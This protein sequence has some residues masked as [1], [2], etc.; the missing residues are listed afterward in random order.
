MLNKLH[1]DRLQVKLLLMV[2]VTSL[3]VF[4]LL[5]LLG[6]NDRAHAIARANTELGSIAHFASLGVEKR[7]APDKV[8]GAVFTSRELTS[9]E[10]SLSDLKRASGIRLILAD[11]NGIVLG[12]SPANPAAIG[13]LFPDQRVLD[14]IRA[15]TVEAFNATDDDSA[16]ILSKIAIV[17]PGIAVAMHTIASIDRA[18]VVSSV[19]NSAY[20][21]LALG[22][23]ALVIALALAWL[24]SRR[25][26][27]QRATTISAVAKQISMGKFRARTGFKS[28]P[29]ELEQIGFVIDRMADSL[30][31]RDVDLRVSSHRLS[32]AQ[33]I[34]MLGQW[35]LDV[36][37]NRAWWSAD[38]MEMFSIKA[39]DDSFEAFL[40]WVHPDDRAHLVAA[41]ARMLATGATMWNIGLSAPMAD[42]VG[43]ML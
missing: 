32:E 35:E 31:Q 25:G 19:T 26:A 14:A 38:A 8:S 39:A 27:T 4:A 20:L 41:N 6:L 43:F 15:G 40:E 9:L 3:P 5:F 18:V 11:R 29:D 37:S 10:K 17:K 33:R 24:L 42:R 2:C 36:P 30:E 23:S 28:S 7:L 13:Q 16:P 1:L 21:S 22:L 12:S 34:A